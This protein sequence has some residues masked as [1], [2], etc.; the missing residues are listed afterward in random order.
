MKNVIKMGFVMALFLTAL[1]ANA[2]DSKLSLSVRSG[3]KLVNFSINEVKNVDVTIATKDKEVLFSERLKSR[4]GKI[5]RTYDLTAF[6]DGTYFLEAAT[7]SEI[8]TYEVTIANNGVIISEKAVAEVYKP[9]L[10]AKDGMVTVIL[11]DGKAPVAIKIY[12]ENNVELYNGTV[13]RTTKFD[14]NSTTAKNVTLVMT[15]NDKMFV[16]TI[17]AR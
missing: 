6:P 11:P 4:E 14:V 15:Y 17:A 3:G 9:L 2:A 8:A 1:V 12:D 16:E 10:N 7:G 13:A 5:S